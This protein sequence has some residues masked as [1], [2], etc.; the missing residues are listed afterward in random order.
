MRG[1]HNN[2][3][4]LI[5]NV[6][7]DVTEGLTIKVLCYSTVLYNNIIIIMTL[8]YIDKTSCN[9]YYSINYHSIT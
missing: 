1:Y 9:T 3:A 2:V 8:Y 6:M 7:E 5:H 4:T